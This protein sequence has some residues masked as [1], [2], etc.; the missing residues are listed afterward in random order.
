MLQRK[1][2]ERLD[3][4]ET[5]KTLSRRAGAVLRVGKLSRL[6]A[7]VAFGVLLVV[8]GGAV[9]GGH[10]IRR[11]HLERRLLETPM[12]SVIN[13]PD[14]VRF[15]DSVARPVYAKHCAVCHGEHMKG[16]P[17]VGAPDLADPVWLYGTGTVFDIDRTILFGIRDARARTRDVTE[18]P[19]FGQRGVLSPADIRNVVQ[20]VLAIS[21]APHLQS[22]VEPGRKV[23]FNFERGNCGDCHGTDAKG[24]NYLGAPD[25]TAGAWDWGGSPSDLYNTVYSGRH[26][27]MPGWF[28]R[29]SLAQIRSLAVYISTA[30]RAARY[31]QAGKKVADN[32]R[33]GAP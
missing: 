6:H 14:L 15:A 19:A 23:F 8:V 18:M 16:N 13:H 26:G 2:T 9:W 20:Y 22:A 10:R 31:H 33:N 30:S 12:D 1:K 27:V 3:V 5:N 29:L 28:G 25:L 7:A 24:D 4:S 21:G 32:S 11:A 17:A